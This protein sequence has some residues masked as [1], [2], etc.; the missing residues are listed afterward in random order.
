MQYSSSFNRCRKKVPLCVDS[1]PPPSTTMSS[2]AYVQ[3]TPTLQPRPNLCDFVRTSL[4]PKP[5]NVLSSLAGLVFL[6]RVVSGFR[7][8]G[9]GTGVEILRRLLGSGTVEDSP[10]KKRAG[11]LRSGLRV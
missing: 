3:H 11:K 9:P 5:I 4:D 6:G 1:K 8:L 10:P 2:V 7:N